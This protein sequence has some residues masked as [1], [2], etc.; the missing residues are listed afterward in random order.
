[1]VRMYGVFHNRS[2][3]L[4]L[5]IRRVVS[6]K[7]AFATFVLFSTVTKHCKIFHF[8]KFFIQNERDD[9]CLKSIQIVRTVTT[10]VI[11]F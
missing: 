10:V 4:H 11:K 6:S 3:I 2:S 7:K 5:V 9:F 8:I 1:M